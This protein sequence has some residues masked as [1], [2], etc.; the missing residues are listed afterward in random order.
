LVDALSGR[1][2]TSEKAKYYRHSEPDREEA[3]EYSLESGVESKPTKLDPSEIKK[4]MNIG[5]L[6]GL[7]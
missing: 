2:I 4:M 7:F 3:Q 5:R 6:F 1:E